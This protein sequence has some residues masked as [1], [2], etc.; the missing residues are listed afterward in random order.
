MVPVT[1]QVRCA[2]EPG[3]AVTDRL[4]GRNGRVGTGDAATAALMVP[5]CGIADAGWRISRHTPA[6]W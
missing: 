6:D 3:K 1:A 4:A 2:A 5:V